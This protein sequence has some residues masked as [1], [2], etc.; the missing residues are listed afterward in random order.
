MIY[1]QFI[2]G[3]LRETELAK[4]QLILLLGT[5]KKMNNHSKADFKPL[6]DVG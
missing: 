4:N 5:L 2:T 3:F 1:V 6:P